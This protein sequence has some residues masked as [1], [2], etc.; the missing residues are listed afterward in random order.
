MAAAPAESTW[1][2]FRD[3]HMRA[4]V[5]HHGDHEWCAHETLALGLDMF[6]PRVWVPVLPRAATSNQRRANNLS[7]EQIVPGR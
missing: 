4:G 3:F 2:P 7:T 5:A 6:R 1:L